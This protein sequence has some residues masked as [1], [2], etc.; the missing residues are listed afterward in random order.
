MIE[1]TSI[2]I[3]AKPERNNLTPNENSLTVSLNTSMPSM[4]ASIE[5]KKIIFILSLL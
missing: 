3:V 5:N 1:G 4:I 2:K